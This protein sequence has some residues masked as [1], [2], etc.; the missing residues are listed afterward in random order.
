MRTR[1]ER[2]RPWWSVR[3]ELPVR[4]SGGRR[5]P[6]VALL[7]LLLPLLGA[8]GSPAAAQVGRSTGLPVPRFVSLASDQVNVRHGPGEQYPIQ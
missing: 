7:I 1:F 2:R 8:A 3:P 4:S 5:R 6:T